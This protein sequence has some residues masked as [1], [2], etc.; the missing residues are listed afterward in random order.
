MEA[1][2]V[3][4]ASLKLKEQGLHPKEIVEYRGPG[5]R[6]LPW[7]SA[8]SELPAHTRQLSVLLRSGVPLV[9]ALK[10]LSDESRGNM[11]NVLVSVRDR[12]QAGASL[13]RAMSESQGVFPEFYVSM[14]AT[15]EASGTLDEVLDG[16]A[17]FLESQESLKEK[18]RS[19]MIYPIIMA[20]V[21]AGVLAFIFTFVIPRI[22]TIFEDSSAALPIS[23][24]ILIAISN[25]FVHYWWLALGLAAALVLGVRELRKRHAE[26]IDEVAMKLPFRSLYFAR[27]ARTMGVLLGGGFP[28]LRSLELSGRATGNRWLENKV[29][30]AAARVSEGARLS[31][32][33]EGIPPVLLQLI[34]TGERSGRLPEVLL[35]AAD[36]YETE[37]DR[38]TQRAL[39]LVEPAM[40]LVMG[41]V[42]GFI[43]LSVLLP[44]FE[45]NELIR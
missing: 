28:M 36:A 45:M 31:A 43:V 24:V 13:S 27:L 44:M 39:T 10:A 16:L 9:E 12:V 3:R 40:I 4:D 21:G 14:V 11:K 20:S 5:K 41:L 26:L 1:D 18:L 15:G 2:G 23:T 17:D 33:L 25:F 32:S 8:K 22:V 30:A 42:V 7:R 34:A 38:R 6:A 19:A 37:F 35:K 29:S